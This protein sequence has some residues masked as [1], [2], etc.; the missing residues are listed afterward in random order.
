MCIELAGSE[1]FSNLVFGLDEELIGLKVTDRK[2]MRGG[3]KVVT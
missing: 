1:M 3:Q 2:R